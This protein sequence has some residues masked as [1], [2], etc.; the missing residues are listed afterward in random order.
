MIPKALVVTRQGFSVLLVG[1]EVV[2]GNRLDT[3]AT[4]QGTP[5]VLGIKEGP[6]PDAVERNPSPRLPRSKRAKR[7]TG[8]LAWEDG[9]DA[10]SGP[11]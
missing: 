7:G 6:P 4:I 9:R 3:E 5:H 2:G 11:D 1:G 10:L 8:I